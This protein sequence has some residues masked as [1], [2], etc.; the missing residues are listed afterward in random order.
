[1]TH[2]FRLKAGPIEVEYEGDAVPDRKA[3]LELVEQAMQ[4]YVDKGLGS[5]NVG[6]RPRIRGTTDGI[7]ARLNCISG[8]ELIVAAAARLTFVGDEEWFSA[9][10]LLSEMKLAT[11]H[12]DQSY[13]AS[14]ERDVKQLVT[15]GKLVEVAPNVFALSATMRRELQQA[16]GE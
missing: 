3:L 15:S 10:E 7:A 11:A 5:T 16:L 9:D 4:S 13:Q 12:Y 6:D 2:R 14:L 8:P 1:M